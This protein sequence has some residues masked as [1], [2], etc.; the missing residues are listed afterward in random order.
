VKYQAKEGALS[1]AAM[2]MSARFKEK[3]IAKANF[4][5]ADKGSYVFQ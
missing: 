3:Q 1:V 2:F 5:A 4:I